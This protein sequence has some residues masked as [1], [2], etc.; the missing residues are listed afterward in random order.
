MKKKNLKSLQINKVLISNFT[1]DANT[2][3]G[4]A[5]PTGTYC[6]T[7]DTCAFTDHYCPISVRLCGM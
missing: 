1:T 4:G 2:I 5:M 6:P 3:K 7:K